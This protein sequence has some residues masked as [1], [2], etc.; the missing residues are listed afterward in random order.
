MIVGFGFTVAGALIY[1]KID[2][3]SQRDWQ[4]LRNFRVWLDGSRFF[5]W[6]AII[7]CSVCGFLLFAAFAKPADDSPFASSISGIEWWVVPAVGQSTWLWGLVWFAGLHL[8]MRKRREYLVVTR[9]PLIHRDHGSE[10]WIQKSEVITH[11]WLAMDQTSDTSSARSSSYPGK[12]LQTVT[13]PVAQGN[14]V[15]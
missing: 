6:H 7:Y 5:P 15:H 11:Q 12:E 14:S 9:F 8:V 10:Q 4:N 1:V 13:V 2:R 3:F